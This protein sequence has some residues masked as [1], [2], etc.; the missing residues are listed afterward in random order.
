MTTTGQ[1]VMLFGTH[2]EGP[3]HSLCMKS[4]SWFQYWHSTDPGIRDVHLGVMGMV[5]PDMESRISMLF[6]RCLCTPTQHPKIHPTPHSFQKME[7]QF[8]FKK[9]K[10]KNKNPK[11]PKYTSQTKNKKKQNPN[12]QPRLWPQGFGLKDQG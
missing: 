12:H 2:L 9:T 1:C 10:P 3:S 5:R 8:C 7:I 4:K 11:L 6:V